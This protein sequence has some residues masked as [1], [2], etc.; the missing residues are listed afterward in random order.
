MDGWMDGWMDGQVTRGKDRLHFK[1]GFPFF[2]VAL[3]THKQEKRDLGFP[4]ATVCL[5]GNPGSPE[6]NRLPKGTSRQGGPSHHPGATGS[7]L[8]TSVGPLKSPLL[9]LIYF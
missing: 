2:K 3:C 1:P 6:Q 8:E 7:G 5:C 4:Y 9:G